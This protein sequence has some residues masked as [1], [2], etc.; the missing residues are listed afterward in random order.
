MAPPLRHDL[1]RI[2]VK[3]TED[4]TYSDKTSHA[5]KDVRLVYRGCSPDFAEWL[6]QPSAAHVVGQSDLQLLPA[7]V[8][9]P[10]QAGEHLVLRDSLPSIAVPSDSANDYLLRLPLQSGGQTQGV[11]LVVV[12]SEALA[13]SLWQYFFPPWAMESTPQQ[14]QFTITQGDELLFSNTATGRRESDWSLLNLITRQL[15]SGVRQ[16]LQGVAPLVSDTRCGQL[17]IPMAGQ[18]SEHALWSLVFWG[19]RPALAVSLGAQQPSNASDL[20]AVAK[21]AHGYRELVSA[22]ANGVLLMAAGMPVLANDSAARM[23]GFDDQQQLMAYTDLLSLVPSELAA[24]L[25]EDDCTK[26]PELQQY[27][28][29]WQTRSGGSFYAISHWQQVQ[30]NGRA[31]CYVS[32]LDISHRRR[33]ELNQQRNQRRFQDFAELAADFFWELDSSLRFNFVSHRFENVLQIAPQN[34]LGLS[35]RQ[36]YERYFPQPASPQWRRHLQAL[37]E[38]KAQHDFEY[39]LTRSDGKERVIKHTCQPV[40][41]EKGNFEGYRGVG[42]DM[43]QD[44]ALAAQVQFHATHDALTSLVNR[45]EFE[46]LLEEALLDAGSSQQQHALCY[47]DLDNFKIVNDSCG[48]SAGDELLRQLGDL[49]RVCVRQSDV[50]ARLGGDEFGILIY[51]CDMARAIALAEKIRVSVMQFE[52][53]WE[54]KRFSIGAS[55]GLSAIES[56]STSANEVMRAADTACYASKERGRNQVTTATEETGMRRTDADR[57]IQVGAMLEEGMFRLWRQPILALNES[58]QGGDY[59]EILLRLVEPDGSLISPASVMPA[60]ERYGLSSKLDRVVFD[61]SL[62]WLIDSRDQLDQLAMCN[63]NLNGPSLLDRGLVEHIEQEIRRSGIPPEKICFEVSETA[64]IANLSSARAVIDKLGKVGCKFALDDFGSGVSSFTFLRGLPINFIKIDGAFVTRLL[65]D[66]VCEEMVGSI[67]RVSH[68][69]NCLTVA[70]SVEDART[71]DALDAI[72]VD[73]AQGFHIARPEPIDFMT[74]P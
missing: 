31:C 58:Y 6:K 57:V 50:V 15:P 51:S 24:M 54:N 2:S 43:T 62:A 21:S 72:G 3:S 64:A 44:H 53:L 38:H 66:Q 73:F 71:L 37:S 34:V 20:P 35:I 67:N 33:A 36:F 74:K 61:R 12:D 8:A 63:I 65:E 68:V 25:A 46:R 69:L 30:W 55:I 41:D 48:H 7:E 28:G 27:E 45:R 9:Q 10:L 39:R 5:L 1:P 11:D 16:W 40:F 60:V 42:R 70:E 22:S 32:L 19:D 4:S 52:F 23:L 49:F 59:F 18:P 14:S 13:Q 29:H 17:D 26:V 56:D 47:V